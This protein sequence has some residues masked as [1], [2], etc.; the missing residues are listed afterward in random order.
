MQEKEIIFH[1]IHND[2]HQIML[3]EWS[4]N[5]TQLLFEVLRCV[6]N[7]DLHKLSKFKSMI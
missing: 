5:I 6:K 2:S 4:M 1:I 7:I 3:T